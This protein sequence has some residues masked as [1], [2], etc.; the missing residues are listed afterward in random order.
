LIRDLHYLGFLFESVV[1]RDLRVYAEANGAKACLY[2]DASGREIDAIIEKANGE[3]AAF[4]VKLGFEAEEEAAK[5]LLGFAELLI[6]KKPMSL[7]VIVGNGFA[8]SRD[9]G[10]NVVPLANLGA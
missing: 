8:H 10:V 6:G 1:I 9:D 2:R 3:F 4:E 7:N 5:N